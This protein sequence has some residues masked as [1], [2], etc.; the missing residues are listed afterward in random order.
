[1]T[2]YPLRIQSVYTAKFRGEEKA[3]AAEFAI[4]RKLNHLRHKGEWLK[5]HEDWSVE[6]LFDVVH[7]IAPHLKRY[8]KFD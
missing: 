2:E 1:M 3:F 5:L 8:S 7:K 6:Q 4:L